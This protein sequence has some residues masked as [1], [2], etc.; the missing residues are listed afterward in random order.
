MPPKIHPEML[1]GS[2]DWLAARCGLL[3][4]SEMKHIITP[5]TLLYAKNDKEKSHLYELTAQRI[6]KFVEPHYIGD[7]MLRGMEDEVEARILYE[8]HYAPV[9]E[10]GFVTNDKWG[11]TLGYSPDGLIGEEGVIE[12]K[13]RR[14][15]F[16]IETILAGDMP[17]DYIIQVQTGLLVSERKWCDFVTY[18]AGLPMLTLR[19]H[20]D[21]KIQ[22]AIVKV[23]EEFE[24]KLTANIKLY[25]QRIKSSVYRT[26]PTE[27]KIEQEM[28][29]DND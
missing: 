1:Q 11:F 13:S 10:A 23:A 7:D 24:K 22:A 19:V 3:T 12:C 25:G 18:S 8:K 6:S 28:I 14:Q 29:I 16:Q 27:R 5:T 17:D 15:K 20:P 9:V 26:I 21:E 4:A 2:D